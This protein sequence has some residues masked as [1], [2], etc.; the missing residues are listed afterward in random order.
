MKFSIESSE[1]TVTVIF[2]RV[3]ALPFVDDV[4]LPMISILLS[5][6]L[7]YENAAVQASHA[8]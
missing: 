8:L 5:V 1:Q 7:V 2:S 6:I 4:V 3:S